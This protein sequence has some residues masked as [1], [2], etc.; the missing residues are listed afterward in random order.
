MIKAVIFDMDG[1][2]IEAKEWHFLALNKALSHFGVAITPEEH[3]SVF[4]GLPTKRKLEI[5]TEEKGF[6]KGLHEF[7]NDLKQQYT[8]EL[9]HAKCR[10]LFI[11]QYALMR[12]R[13]SGFKIGLATNSIPQTRNLMMNYA[14]LADLLDIQV[15]AVD[16]ERG[17]PAPDIYLEAMRLLDVEP[18]ETLIV[19]DNPHGIAAAEASGAFVMKVK[20]VHDVTL[21][22]ILNTL[23]EIEG[24]L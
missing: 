13:E 21:R 14:K 7:V 6:P 22:N 15:S 8:V 3:H 24:K 10:P 4:D 12:L 23:E 16:V 2:L 5:L 11:H 1:V 9:I 17:K 20:E 19:E 18:F